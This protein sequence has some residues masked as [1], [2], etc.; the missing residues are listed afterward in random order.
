MYGLKKRP[1]DE[2]GLIQGAGTGT[3]D[4]VK[5]NVPAG[6]YIMPADSTQQIGTNNL[7]NMGNPTPV[8]LSNGEFQ[9]SPDQV[10]SVGVQTLDAMKDQTHMPVDQPQLGFKPG[11]SKPELFFANG[12]LVPS[13]YPSADDIRR[14]QQNRIGGPQMRDVTPVNRQLPATST[15]PS[16][17]SSPSANPSN[18]APT[19]GGGFGGGIR[20]FVNNSKLVKG[21][22]YLGAASSLFANA[23]TPS[24]DYRERFGLGDQSPE[25]LGTAK[26]F[27]KDFG[28]RALGYASDLGNALTFGQAGRFYADKQRIASEAKATQPEFNSKQNNPNAVVDNPFGNTKTPATTQTPAH[29]EVQTSSNPVQNSN[30]Y[31]IQQKGNSFSYANPGAAAQARADGIR[32]GEG[33]GLK[34]N[35]VNDPRGVENLFANTQEMGPTEQQV[36]NA[37]AQREMNLGLGMRGYGNNP[38]QAPQRNDAQEAERQAVIRAASTPIA[39]ARG[40]TANQVRT[41]SDLQQGEDNRANQRY[42]TDANNVAALQREAMGQAGQNYRTELGEQGTNNRFNANLGFDA[43]KFQATNDLANREFNLNATEKGFG[44]RNSARLEKLY[45]QYDSAKSDEDR[46]S[47]QEKINRYTGNKADTGKDRYMTVG[48]G[49]VYDKESGLINQPQQLFDTQTQQ[50]VNTPAASS[51]NLPN[52]MTRQVGTSNGKPVYEDAQGNRFIGN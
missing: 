44:I 32:E 7:K 35:P 45:E 6:S 33:L 34:V 37:I 24:E 10:H 18:P 27:A 14:A 51:T 36:Q 30:P 12:G 49:Q 43:Q 40:L 19:Q 21:V 47:I 26:G 50:F 2:I 16:T 48:G 1:K 5:K 29:Q 46:K 9:L 25:D 39:G 22:G 31:A 20:N 41:L 42:T 3:S 11:Q 17:T 23:A 28:V 38:V 4:D 8:N 52:G 15:T 13:A